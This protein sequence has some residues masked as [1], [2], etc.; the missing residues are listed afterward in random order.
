M[1]QTP[2]SFFKEETEVKNWIL[3]LLAVA[4]FCMAVLYSG[5]DCRSLC[6][7]RMHVEHPRYEDPVTLLHWMVFGYPQAI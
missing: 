1:T 4:L 2:G 3:V 7:A 6:S 5:C